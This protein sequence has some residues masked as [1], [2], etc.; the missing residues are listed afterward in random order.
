MVTFLPLSSFELAALLPPALLLLLAVVSA[1]L[2]VHPV[3]RT[4]APIAQAAVDVRRRNRRCLVADM[5]SPRGSPLAWLPGWGCDSG[6]VSAGCA[7]RVRGG[8]RARSGRGTGGGA[9]R[10]RARRAARNGGTGGLGCAA[11]QAAA[12][13]VAGRDALL[14]QHRQH[15]D[16][17]L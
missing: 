1:L 15:D 8:C 17:A 10:G 4:T 12:A 13:G 16:H 7:D 6:P 9:G 2:L 3:T 5:L 14:Q 11:P